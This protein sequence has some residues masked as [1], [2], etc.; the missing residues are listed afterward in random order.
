[1]SFRLNL[2]PFEVNDL[3][4]SS[5]LTLLYIMSFFFIPIPVRQSSSVY[6]CFLLNKF[7]RKGTNL[8]L[9][10][11]SCMM[12]HK[13]NQLYSAL[14]SGVIII[15]M[16]LGPKMHAI[17]ASAVRRKKKTHQIFKMY[18][19]TCYLHG[20]LFHSIKTDSLFPKWRQIC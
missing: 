9:V 17:S 4:G 13:T 11:Q 16:L 20:A 3:N 1:M 14:Q 7:E 19:S 15:I 5:R 18:F 6:F 8:H 12:A 2:S 10:L